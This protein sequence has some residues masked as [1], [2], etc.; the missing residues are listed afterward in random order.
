MPG[1]LR[2]RSGISVWAVKD[3]CSADHAAADAAFAASGAHE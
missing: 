3:G 1:E 2:V